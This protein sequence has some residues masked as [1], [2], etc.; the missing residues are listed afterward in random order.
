MTIGT[1]LYETNFKYDFSQMKFVFVNYV[2]SISPLGINLP[3]IF[4]QA[5]D[6]FPQCI[7]IAIGLGLHIEMIIS[8]FS[9]CWLSHAFLRISRRSNR[10]P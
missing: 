6:A 9:H 4:S 1:I 7:A 10:I 8:P 2:E 3:K 5:Q